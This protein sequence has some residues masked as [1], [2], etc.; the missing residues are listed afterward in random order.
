MLL[1]ARQST[2]IL[3]VPSFLGTS[4]TGTAHAW[5]SPSHALSPIIHLLAVEAPLS[6]RDCS[7]KLVG[8]E[9]LHR[10]QNQFDVH[11]L[12]LEVTRG[13]FPRGRHRRTPGNGK[14]SNGRP[15]PV[16][17]DKQKPRYKEYATNGGGTPQE[18]PISSTKMNATGNS[19]KFK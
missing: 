2:H 10:E 18:I 5:S 13:E 15:R 12:G 9:W 6:P 7:Y 19:D 16:V 8:L 17:Y 3:H 11:S 4:K 14:D 1:M